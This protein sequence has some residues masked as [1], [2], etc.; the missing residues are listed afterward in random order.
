MRRWRGRARLLRRRLARDDRARRADGDRRGRL[1][2]VRRHPRVRPPHRGVPLQRAVRRARLRAQVLGVLRE[3]LRPRPRRTAGPGVGG[4]LLPP[5]PAARAGRRPTRASSTPTSA[6]A[7][8]GCS[9]RTPARWR[10]RAATSSSRGRSRPSRPSAGASPE[11]GRTSSASRSR[12]P[13]TA[14]CASSCAG[15]A[16]RGTTCGSAR[17]AR[18][19]DAPAATRRATA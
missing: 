13:S 8:H 1:D 14:P 18:R 15:R 10:P 7:S 16:G 6:G 2:R 11:T 9:G 17:W 19:A 5:E 3:G 12:S 4:A